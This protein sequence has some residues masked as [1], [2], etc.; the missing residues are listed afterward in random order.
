MV[1]NKNWIYTVFI[2]SLFCIQ[3]LSAQRFN[4]FAIS[5]LTASQIDGDNLAGFR[6]LGYTLGLGVHYDFDKRYYGGLELLNT[7]KGSQS[8]L[9]LSGSSGFSSTSLNY[10]EVP[11]YA[12]IRDW[13]IDGEDYY[14]VGAEGGLSIGNL[15]NASS[16]NTAY[17]NRTDEFNRIDISYLLGV[18][19]SFSKR[20]TAGARYTRAF[21]N[22]F[23]DEA[24]GIERLRSYNWSFRM[25]FHF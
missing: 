5:G 4:A 17:E 25:Q 21:T 3:D 15:I 7:L 14:K 12:G 16:E 23:K 24:T 10:L 6:K 9:S 22:L 2:A 8:K 1:I 19:Y 13:Y 18:Y 11:I 20:W